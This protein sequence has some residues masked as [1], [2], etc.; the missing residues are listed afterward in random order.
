MASNTVYD[1]DYFIQKFEAIPEN[2]WCRASYGR[3]GGPRCAI[4]HCADPDGGANPSNDESTALRYLFMSYY[5]CSVISVNDK[6]IDGMS[7]SPKLRIL[8]ALR[9]I[10]SK[11]EAK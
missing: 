6:Y 10:K 5:G 8:A 9:D 3:N 11:Q 4:G 1:V 7:L 2:L